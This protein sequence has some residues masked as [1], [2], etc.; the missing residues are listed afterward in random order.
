MNAHVVVGLCWG[1]EGKGTIVDSL[2]RETGAVGVVR[3]NGGPQAA[4]HVVVDGHVHCFAQ[5]GAGTFAGAQTFLASPCASDLLALAREASV[6]EAAGVSDPL[7]RVTI[8]PEVVLVTPWHKLLNRLSEVLRGDARHGSCGMGVGQA[9]LDAEKPAMPT[10]RMAQTQD[11]SALRRALR[12]LWLVKVD[13]AEQAAAGHDGDDVTALIDDLRDPTRVDAL[14]SEYAEIAG[15]LQIRDALPDLLREGHVIFEGAQG[16]LLDRVQGDFPFVTPSYVT[17]DRALALLT[18]AAPHATARVLGV[19]RTYATRHGPGPFPTEDG[20]LA[21]VWPELHNGRNPWQGP[22][23]LGHVHLPSLKRSLAACAGHVDALAITC[24]DRTEE[25]MQALRGLGLP[26]AVVS[27]GVEA[28]DKEW[29][30]N[31]AQGR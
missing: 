18:Q 23:R 9:L 24:A 25:P 13:Q 6:L 30:V 8:A 20:A 29:A 21:S 17:P 16:V 22:M 14:A 31:P 10:L 26:V 3:F 12:H 15:Q 5:F 28:A 2:V 11:H 7:A 27:H 1:D 19:T 4:H